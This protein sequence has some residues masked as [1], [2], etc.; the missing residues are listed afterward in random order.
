MGS[1]LASTS[2]PE[3]GSAPR[4]ETRAHVDAF[5]QTTAGLTAARLAAEAA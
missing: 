3:L 5:L 2:S 1:A 4:K